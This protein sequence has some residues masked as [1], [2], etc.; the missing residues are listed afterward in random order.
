MA[1]DALN[2]SRR[3]RSNAGPLAGRRTLAGGLLALAAAAG[4]S[5]NAT[6]AEPDSDKPGTTADFAN[7]DF[8]PVLGLAE[9]MGS[10][11]EWIEK[12]GDRYPTMWLGAATMRMTPQQLTEMAAKEPEAVA[13]MIGCILNL[14]DR[15]EAEADVMRAAS[16]R[17]IAGCCKAGLI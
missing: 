1:T 3:S 5:P 4:T 14:R 2:T 16:V 17:L 10:R 7:I 13:D 8:E 9:A 6:A 11:A 12:M 15:L